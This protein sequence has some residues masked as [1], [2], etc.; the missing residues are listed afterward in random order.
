VI[1]A[2]LFNEPHAEG[3]EPQGTGACWGCGDTAKDWRLAAERIGNA[4]LQTNSNWLIFVE[5]VSCDGNGGSP[6]VY[7][8]VPDDPM[9]CGWW[10]GNLS[11]AGTYPVRL[12]VV[13][14]PE[15][16]EQPARR[17]GSLLGVPVQAE[18]R[19]GARR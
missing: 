19:P 4:I 17:L 6:N 7:D 15:L 5:G 8:N 16:P 1:G 2:D 14:G 13:Q 18:H 12:N 9:A 10:G 11:K 3:T